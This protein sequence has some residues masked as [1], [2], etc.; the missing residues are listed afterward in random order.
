[1][2]QR[3]LTGEPGGPLAADLRSFLLSRWDASPET[4]RSYRE[5]ILQLEAY[6]VARGRS[7]ATRQDI[8]GWL[9]EMARDHRP[10]TVQTRFRAARAMF[11]WRAE[12]DGLPDPTAKVRQPRVPA[13]P[14]PVPTKAEVQALRDACRG[15]GFEERRDAAILTMMLA[16]G[17]RLS[18]VANIRLTDIDWDERA[19]LVTGKGRKIRAVPFD[20]VAARA[21]DRYANRPGGRRS[22][23]DAGSPWLWLGTRGRLTAKGIA[24]VCERRSRAAGVK[25]HAH[26]ARHW[27]ASRWLEDGGSEGD[28]MRIAGWSSRRMLDRYGA[29]EADRRA[30]AAYREWSPFGDR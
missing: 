9:A 1:M 15:D 2:D 16:T 29:G 17:M 12:E 7:E 3:S 21:I 22:H 28:L 20:P 23:P 27:L 4:R 24:K 26:L 30:R 8:E 25:F 18:E 11:R 19:I 13:E 10:S 5:S 14:V 6:L